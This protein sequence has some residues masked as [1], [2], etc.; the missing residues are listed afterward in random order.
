MES[1]GTGVPTPADSRLGVTH[2]Q[3]AGLLPQSEIANMVSALHRAR[4]TPPPLTEA[5]P[6]RGFCS[7]CGF[8]VPVPIGGK[9]TLRAAPDP[10]IFQGI[11]LARNDQ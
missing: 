3:L 7:S 6:E 10:G 2:P 8:A 1:S 4:L 11:A 9:W 5:S